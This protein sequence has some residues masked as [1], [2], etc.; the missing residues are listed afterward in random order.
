M[1]EYRIEVEIQTASRAF[2]SKLAPVSTECTLRFNAASTAYLTIPDSHALV[3]TLL[4]DGVRA[5]VWLVMVDGNV[6]TTKR[7]LEGPVGDIYGDGP[8]GT[9]TVPVIDDFAWLSAVLGFPVPTASW[10]AQTSEYARYT[11]PSESRALAAILANKTRLNLPWDVATSLGRGTSGVTELRMHR[12]ADKLIPPLNEDRLQLFLERNAT[13]N[14]W[15]VGVRAGSTYVRPLTP[16]SGVLGA[17]KWKRQRPSLTRVIV[18]GA[19]EGVAREFLRVT[20]SALQTQLGR[21]LEGFDDSRGA[22]AGADLTPYGEAALA[23]AAGKSSV[24]ATLRE[25]S[26]F[27]FPTAYDLG[28]KVTIQAGAMEAEDIITEI[29]IKHSR[30]QG[31]SAEPKVGFATEAPQARLTEFVASLA[32]SVRN[33]ERR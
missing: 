16:Q 24:T 12:L 21:I 4:D 28:T 11:G 30:D 15:D 26:W 20:D 33:L 23:E 25:T 5:A 31:F 14:R 1:R 3:P 2:I 29:S 22:D 27:R 18:G 13:T 17:W 10:T 19:G 9:V 32:A 8:F 7:L 6:L